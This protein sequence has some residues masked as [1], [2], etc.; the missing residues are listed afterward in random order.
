MK[1]AMIGSYGHVDAVLKSA[2]MEKVEFAAAARWG[3]DDPMGYLK[4]F[5]SVPKDLPIF[6][7][8]RK[9]LDEV[10]PDV[11]GVFMPLYRNG[12]AS[13]AAVQAG[14]H[15][16]GEKPLATEL[17]DLDKLRDAIASAGVQAN[18]VMAMRC[19]PAF[20]AAR[21]IVQDGR[22]GEP[23]LAFGQKSY[24]FNKRDEF[25]IR[26]ETYGGS[27]PWQAI[28]AIDFVSYCTGKDY[29][30]VMAM[31]SNVGHPSRPGMEDN[32]GILFEFAG[33]GHA[34]I[35]FDFFRPW[36]QQG[37]KWGDDRLRIVGTEAVVEV[38][39]EGQAVRLM[40]ADAVE[41][42]P[43]P[44]KRDLF[45]E[46]LAAIDGTGEGLIT[47]AESLRVTEVAIKAR[48]AADTGQAVTL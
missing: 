42:V 39:D 47:T 15:V 29:A 8:Y 32:G 19:Q 18:A 33:G 16:I 27:I 5:P 23:V 41:D 20:Q 21:T 37:R 17:E 28:H 3:E 46:F 4:K 7:D 22:I 25:Y 9:M 10:R 2:G 31:H 34:V 35:S 45:A 14:A 43:L 26:R 44:A 38:I 13:L 24:P 30:R 12:E 40:T 11:V 1:L 36:G 6:D 48:Q